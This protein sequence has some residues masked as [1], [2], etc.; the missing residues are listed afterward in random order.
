MSRVTSTLL[1]TLLI[2]SRTTS[3]AAPSDRLVPSG[4]GMLELAQSI[5]LVRVVASFPD[6]RF[7]PEL[8]SPTVFAPVIG[9]VLVLKSWWGPF[10]TGR[11]LYVVAPVICAGTLESCT[12]YPLHTGDELLIFTGS[13][14]PIMATQAWVWPAAESQALMAAVELAVKEQHELE[15]PQTDIARAPER[16]RAMQALKECFAMA[17]S[18]EEAEGCHTID[19]SALIGIKRSDLAAGLGPPQWC[20][21]SSPISYVPP[22][23]ADCPPEQTPIWTFGHPSSN[24]ICSAGKDLR[25]DPIWISPRHP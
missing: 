10:S 8:N 21:R 19:R 17:S 16:H 9:K 3:G 7:P 13:T 4:R 2:A 22:T 14:E 11:V 5:I 25:C 18:E 15:D 1:A 24:F 6:A 20:Q 12:A 23:G